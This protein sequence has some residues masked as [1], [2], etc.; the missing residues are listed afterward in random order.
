MS[1]LPKWFWY[2]VGAAQVV[3]TIYIYPEAALDLQPSNPFELEPGV[4]GTAIVAA[5][6]AVPY[7]LMI[8]AV[9]YLLACHEAGKK[10]SEFA[11]QTVGLIFLA[12]VGLGVLSALLSPSSCSSNPSQEYR[13]R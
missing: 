5:I 2:A 7:T 8:A 1:K 6:R 3:A 4:L 13:A 9:L 12:A 10:I 11:G